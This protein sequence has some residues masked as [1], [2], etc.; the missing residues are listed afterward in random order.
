MELWIAT[1]SKNKINEYEKLLNP[2]GYHVKSLLD[3]NELIEIEETG[4]T[5]EENAVL[6]AQTLA[7]RTDRVWIADDSGFEVDALNKEPGIYS[8]RYMGEDTS[9]DIKNKSI[10]DRI[11]NEDNRVCRYVCVLALCKKNEDPILFKGVI[12]GEVSKTAKGSFGFGYDPIFYYPEF[13][14]TF[15]E[16]SEIEKNSVSHRAKACE[17]LVEYLNEN[18]I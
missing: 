3:L 7:D 12:E 4:K 13:K 5:F 1:Q 14:K 6:K 8:A 2:L 17:K 18:T 15:A 11:E 9:Y 16:V 10:L